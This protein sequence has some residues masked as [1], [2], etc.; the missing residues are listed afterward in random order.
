MNPSIFRPT[1]DYAEKLKRYNFIHLFFKAKI[2]MPFMYIT[3]KLLKRYMIKERADIPDEPYNRNFF[4]MWD[5]FE[6]YTKE[7]WWKFK[8]IDHMEA[9]LKKQHEENY[10]SRANPRYLNGQSW[11]KV[12]HFFWRLWLTIC[13]EDTAYREINNFLLHGIHEKMNKE[14]KPEIKHEHIMYTGAYDMNLGYFI[15]QLEKQGV[16]PGQKLVIEIGAKEEIQG[17]SSETITTGVKAGNSIKV[18]RQDTETGN[19]SGTSITCKPE[20]RKP[21]NP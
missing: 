5:A 10:Y 18:E 9:N 8:N 7:W 14:Y 6:E 11:Y 19:L 13:L 4:I 15:K 1:K 12:L 3:E 20:T 16:K 2:F 21:Q 17:G